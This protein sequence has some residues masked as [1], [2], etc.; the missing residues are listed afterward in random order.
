[1]GFGQVPSVAAIAFPSARAAARRVAGVAAAARIVRELSEAGFSG[2]WIRVADG[3]A[4]DAAALDDVARLAGSMVVGIGE[5][6]AH[7]PVAVM[8]GGRLIP[9]EAIAAFLAGDRIGGGTAIDLTRRDATAEILR[10]TGKVT[11]GPVSRWINRP[12]SRA[13]SAV[14]LRIPGLLPIHA[15]AGNAVLAALMFGALVLGGSWGLIVGGLLFHAA[16]VF[17]GVDGEVA[18]AT[19][20]SSAAGATFDRTVDM[21]TTF[22]FIIGLAVNLVSSGQDLA[23][24]LA[25]W[26]VALVAI[27]LMLVRRRAG[28]SNLDQL[29]HHYRDRCSG[30]LVRKIMAFLT[31]ISSRDFFALANAAMIVVGFPMGP[32]YG[33]AA[34]ASVWIVFVAAWVAAPEDS[35]L[36]AENA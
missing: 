9:S 19:F 34:S 29:K 15:T 7:E 20:R 16:S 26:S 13:L 11:D 32:L 22:L 5:P 28:S 10:R 35:R 36:P 3:G 21:A 14:L 23:L 1:M 27:G 31:I 12:V 18:R 33:F 2:V 25:A 30:P 4:I 24:A 6:P 17:D 8:P